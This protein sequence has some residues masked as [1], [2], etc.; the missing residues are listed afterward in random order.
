MNVKL[1]L[2]A[3][4]FV[5]QFLSNARKILSTGKGEVHLRRGHEGPERKKIL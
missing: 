1:I 5:F 4:S 2:I 3:A